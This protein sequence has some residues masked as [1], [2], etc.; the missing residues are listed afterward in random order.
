MLNTL[1]N[2]V[3]RL[4]LAAKAGLST[5]I[6]CFKQDVRGIAAVEMAFIFPVML[7]LYFGLVDV[8]NLLSANRKVT[9]A[10]S[11]IADLVTQ[12][13]GTV[14][15]ADLNGFFA[16]ASPVMDP[17]SAAA[18]GLELFAYEVD[19]EGN[20]GLLWEKKNSGASCG[21]TPT[22]TS[23][24]I[25]LMQAGTGLIL[26]RVCYTWQPLA[27]HV[28]G[29]APMTVSDEMILRPRQSSS[30]ECTDCP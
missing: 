24:M 18:V 29:S 8:T 1:T 15:E 21:A 27:G 6:N 16:A 14:T 19:S 2:S 25:T 7:I 17:F 3:S 20:A 26:A 30:I 9:L 13:S 12:A 28:L 11:T 10:S 23:E 22:A 5:R 4:A